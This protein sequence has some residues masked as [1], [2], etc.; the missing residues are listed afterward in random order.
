MKTI[1]I[2]LTRSSTIV[3]RLVRTFTS[4]TYTHV[5]ISFNEN[6]LPL[7]SSSRKNGRTLLPAGPCTEVFSKGYY[8]KHP[9]IPYALYELKVSDEVY[10]RAKS[11]AERIILNAGEYHF[12]VL[13]LL[14]CR[15]NIVYHRKYHFF[16][17]QFVSEVLRRS[18]ALT[19]PK[20]TALM[21]PM[22]YTKIPELVCI[23]RGIIHTLA[24][25]QMI[26]SQI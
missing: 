19:L 20:D 12:N 7:Y 5:S 4:D 6:L 15:L 26:I 3:S 8:G 17:S 11:E 2:L 9:F 13:G 10:D 23:S 21:R 16:C 18:E 24:K 14:L 22:D 1:Y 25:K